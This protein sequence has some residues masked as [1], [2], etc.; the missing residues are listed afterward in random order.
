[1]VHNPFCSIVGRISVFQIMFDYEWPYLC[2]VGWY[3]MHV[4]SGFWLN[5]AL[6]NVIWSNIQLIQKLLNCALEFSFFFKELFHMEMA[7][8]CM[9]EPC[10]ENEYLSLNDLCFAGGGEWLWLWKLQWKFSVCIGK[11]LPF[12]WC[13]RISFVDVSVLNVCEI[14]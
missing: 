7:C 9:H 2:A 6:V 11:M 10:P 1:M 4:P 8:I 13:W 14:G 5:A 3:Y 12:W